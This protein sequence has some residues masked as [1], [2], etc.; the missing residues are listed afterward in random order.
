MSP[1][2]LVVM[3]YIVLFYLFPMF[4]NLIFGQSPNSIYHYER[5]R[6]LEVLLFLCLFA[7]CFTPLFG[8]PTLNL[9]RRFG[10]RV[11]AGAYRMLN[12]HVL[13]L[14]FGILVVTAG[15]F[16]PDWA[17]YRYR[18]TGISD[19]GADLYLVLT[20][21]AIANALLLWLFSEHIRQSGEVGFR[22]RLSVLILCGALFY[23]ASGTGD[24]FV[25]SLYLLLFMIP[26]SLVQFSTIRRH[27]NLLSLSALYKNLGAIIIFGLLMM[28][29]SIGE[30]IKQGGSV[31]ESIELAA[32]ERAEGVDSPFMRLQEGLSSHYYSALQFFD[33]Y[34]TERLRYYAAPISYPLQSIIYRLRTL[35][36]DTST[37]RPDITS[38]SLL[39][40]RV[41]S[42]Y[43]SERQGTSPGVLGSFAYVAPL[44][45]ATVLAVLYLIIIASLTNR[46]F[47]SSRLKFSVIGGVI[48]LVQ[49]H[50][51]FES[52]ID[53][54][55][56]LDNASVFLATFVVLAYVTARASEAWRNPQLRDKPNGLQLLQ[57]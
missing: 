30:N 32:T 47:H 40:F 57:P 43:Q 12:R 19:L 17:N 33:G 35:R 36:G 44:P 28:S 15:M 45:I 7:A 13:L 8:E 29:I 21:N 11:C 46:M 39:N 53:F 51:L 23:S 6:M 48:V 1:G 50:I 14:S 22:L 25:V 52:P 4:G 24:M 10:D 5:P 27:Q 31:A 34:A 37:E 26:K 54:I 55:L 18:D 42:D 3:M 9:R 49:T 41:L 56:I 2:R 20:I 16:S 38:I